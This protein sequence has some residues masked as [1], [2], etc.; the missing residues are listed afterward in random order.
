MEDVNSSM[1]A[2]PTDNV[3]LVDS[4]LFES[5]NH[6]VSCE[7][8]SWTAQYCSSLELKVFYFVQIEPF[9]RVSIETLISKAYPP[10]FRASIVQIQIDVNFTNYNI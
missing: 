9:P 3:Q 5:L 4:F 8:P 10:Y 1:R 2:I 6:Q 7:T